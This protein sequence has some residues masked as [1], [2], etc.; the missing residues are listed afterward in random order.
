MHNKAATFIGHSKCLSLKE[1]DIICEIENL[2]HD[3][4]NR[5]LCG[6]MGQFDWICARCVSLLKMRFPSIKSNLILPYLNFNIREPSYFDEIIFPIG[7]ENYHFKSAIL[8]RNQYLVDNTTAAICYINHDWGGAA[9]TYR[10]AVKNKLQIIN[11]GI[12]PIE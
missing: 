6:G 7:F 2:I 8:K 1:A 12:L 10:R 4:Y 5:F 11:L 9:K 3:G